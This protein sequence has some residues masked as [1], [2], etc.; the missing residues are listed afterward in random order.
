MFLIQLSRIGA[1]GCHLFHFTITSSMAEFEFATPEE[2]ILRQFL[3]TVN[4]AKV[5]YLLQLLGFLIFFDFRK[6][7]KRRNQYMSHYVIKT[8]PG[9]RMEEVKDIPL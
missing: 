6:R 4:R 9:Q 5:S 7:G 2:S 8:L 3:N 1:I